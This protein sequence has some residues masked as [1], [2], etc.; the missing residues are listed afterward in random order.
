MTSLD[1]T[2]RNTEALERST[3]RENGRRG[4]GSSLSTRDGRDVGS[5]VDGSVTLGAHPV[6]CSPDI[7][8]GATGCGHVWHF[9][10]ASPHPHPKCER[11]QRIMCG[12]CGTARSK[13][14][15]ATRQSR[16]EPCAHSHRLLL[17]RVIVSGVGDAPEVGNFFWCTLTAPGADS[18]PWD[19]SRCSHGPEVDCSG[20]L[21]CK[22][23]EW[24]SAVWNGTAP[25]RWSWFITYLRRRLGS[26]QFV[27]VWEDQERG[28]LHRHFLIRLDSPSTEKRVRAAV[29]NIGQRW[30]FGRQYDVRAITSSAANE[31]WY[32]ASYATKTVDRVADRRVL[33][34]R[35]GEMRRGGGGFRSWSASRSWGD[36]CKVVRERQRVWA[37]SGG[38][39][40]AGTPGTVGAAGALDPNERISTSVGVDTVDLL[41]AELEAVL[42]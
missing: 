35:T 23:D 33:N 16:C 31:A 27:G 4:R 25:K 8:G 24:D 15:R 6:R 10:G 11:P 42:L 22:V 34:T 38:T 40:L 19:S 3:E 5:D 12:L 32:I 1:P 9:A 41:R 17:K 30:G 2:D 39:A 36:T 29:R 37:V 28:V 21:G 18:L 14:C 20:K 7:G 13:R 26:L